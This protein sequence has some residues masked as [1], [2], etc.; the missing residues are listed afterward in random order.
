[1]TENPRLPKAVARTSTGRVRTGNEDAFGFL[2]DH[3]IYVVCDGMGGAAGGEVASRLAVD[4]VLHRIAAENGA[5]SA[6]DRIHEAITEANRTVLQRA[7]REPGLYG[8]GTTLVALMVGQ[9]PDPGKALI[10]HAGDSRCY[11]FR[12]GQLSLCTHDHSLVDEQMRLGTMT[13]EEAERSPFRSVITRAIGTQETVS[14]EILEMDT[15]AGDLFLLCTD[16][17]TREISEESIAR[18]LGSENDFQ[19]AAE[20]LVDEANEAGGRDN[21]T[22]L[23]VHMPGSA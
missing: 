17:L 6:R 11:L 20:R 19:R 22:C 14:E 8:M 2:P 16:G 15:E 4:T 1:M 5:G 13:R 7:D 9:Q 10:A 3:G 12:R 23:L 18:V 21:V